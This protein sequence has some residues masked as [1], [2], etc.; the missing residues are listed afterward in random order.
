M[1]PIPSRILQ[2][3]AGT[4]LCSN[5]EVSRCGRRPQLSYRR[6]ATQLLH[7][8]SSRHLLLRQL[9]ANATEIADPASVTAGSS[10]SDMQDVRLVDLED[11]VLT[12]LHNLGYA[13]DEAA[14]VAEVRAELP[15]ACIPHVKG[16]SISLLLLVLGKTFGR[17]NAFL[18][19]PA[20]TVA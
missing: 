8:K 4:V 7:H 9:K 16:S 18:S 14:V 15:H 1:A 5:V 12:A 10:S 20:H 13:S 19:F 11:L 3:G 2:G 17:R 6:L